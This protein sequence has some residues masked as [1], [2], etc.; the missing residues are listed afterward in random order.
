M[1][2]FKKKFSFDILLAIQRKMKMT[3][4][5]ILGK[6]HAETF[7]VEQKVSGR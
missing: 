3:V 5:C 7:A 2:V 4:H 6:R 1:F